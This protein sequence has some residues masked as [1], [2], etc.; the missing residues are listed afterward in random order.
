V[1]SNNNYQ[2]IR[3][4][5]VIINSILNILDDG[6]IVLS[7]GDSPS[8]IVK[9][10]QIVYGNKDN[11]TVINNGIPTTKHI[12]FISFPISSVGSYVDP[13][14][15]DNYLLSIITNNHISSLSNIKYLDFISQGGSYKNILKSLQRITNSNIIIPTINLAE[16]Q[17]VD[18][19]CQ[20]AL[21]FI[22]DT[23]EGTRSRCLPNFNLYETR[24][25]L[26]DS[27]LRCNVVIAI[28]SL[29]LIN[30]SP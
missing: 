5:E 19:E 1:L 11:Y 6:D 18:E 2:C 10:I 26:P 29:L 14:V 7:P 23:S 8:K 30:K 16:Y 24:S 25:L 28:L 15:I 12:R 13:L 22:F 21:K 4:V 3:F 17:P 20:N 9:I 27:L